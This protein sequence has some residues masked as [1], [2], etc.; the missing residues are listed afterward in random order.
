[1]ILSHFSFDADIFKRK[2]LPMLHGNKV[3][4]KAFNPGLCHTAAAKTLWV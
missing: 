4:I 3:I 1:M 2:Q